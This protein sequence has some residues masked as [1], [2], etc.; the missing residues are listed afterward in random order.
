MADKFYSALA[1]IDEGIMRIPVLRV[2]WGM[3][4]HPSSPG[5]LLLALSS[6]IIMVAW[7][8]MPI[9][10][11]YD[12]DSW[13][14]L[15]TGREIVQ[16][17]IPYANPFA[18]DAPNGEYAIVVQQWLHCVLL[19]AGYLAF[20]YA[21]CSVVTVVMAAV[22]LGVL[23]A[24]LRIVSKAAPA[25][26]AACC[27]LAVSGCMFYMSNRPTMWTMMAVCGVVALCTLWRRTGNAKYLIGLP[28]IMLAH[29]QLHMSMMWLDVFT[30]CCFMLPASLKDLREGGVKAHLRSCLP[31]IAAAVAMCAAAFVNP[32]GADGALYLFK[33]Y[34]AAGYRD[35]ISELGSVATASN[36]VIG[37]FVSYLLLPVLGAVA[38]RRVPSLPLMLL[39][40]AGSA[41]FFS[42][43]RSVWIA[44]LACALL[45]ASQRKPA[46]TFTEGERLDSKAAYIMMPLLVSLAA[47]GAVVYTAVSAPKD[48]DSY[49]NIA[50]AVHGEGEFYYGI[51]GF[52]HGDEVV[53]PL[54]DI[55]VANP[56]RT[57][58]SWEIL[59]SY[60]EWRGAKVVF[61]TR[62]EVWEPGISGADAH[63]WQDF[64]DHILDGDAFDSY[65]TQGNWRWYIVSAD[66]AQEYSEALGL[67][68]VATTGMF[69]LLQPV[70]AK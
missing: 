69:T 39:W 30:A 5:D 29:A 8:I 70:G 67:E 68:Q 9:D 40:L 64:V 15:S 16:N 46:S 12:T 13:F 36:L 47:A 57:Y 28:V 21:G 53:G 32:Y 26:V 59:N 7:L 4:A 25:T 61:D 54:A 19:Y 35:A 45:V 50:G 27:T 56:G 33:S 41:A 18:Y 23:Y 62:P 17:G 66:L 44:G 49:S 10:G 60:L 42:S 11:P 55:V 34:G 52:E 2:G 58:V 65:M 38:T 22:F 31:L 37:V 63:P 51:V 24:T 20:G 3:F 43:I 48:I 1:R 14:L 6:L